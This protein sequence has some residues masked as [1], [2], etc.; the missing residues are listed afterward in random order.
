MF[1]GT[2]CVSKLY[3]SPGGI[4]THVLPILSRIGT[5]C[6]QV[7]KSNGALSAELLDYVKERVFDYLL[8]TLQ[9]FFVTT[10]CFYADKK[11]RITNGTIRDF[12]LAF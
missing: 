9:M 3:C 12:Y 2:F 8:I 6:C 1:I 5:F 11:P 4:R 7:A 10:Q